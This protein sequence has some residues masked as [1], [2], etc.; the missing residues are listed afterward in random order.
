M[1][2]A[3]IAFIFISG[4]FWLFN[5][6]H[7]PETKNKSVDDITNDFKRAVNKPIIR[8]CCTQSYSQI[9]IDEEDNNYIH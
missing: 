2:Y 9:T 4:L 5:Y 8:C 1:P 3:F 7:L 6:F